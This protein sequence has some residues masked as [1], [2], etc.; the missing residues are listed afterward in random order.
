MEVLVGPSFGIDVGDRSAADHQHSV[1]SCLFLEDGIGRTGDG[2]GF[3]LGIGGRGK[4]REANE[5]SSESSSSIGAPDDSEDEEDDCASSKEVLSSFKG[6]GLG[7]MGSMEDTL[8][9]KYIFFP[10]LS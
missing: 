2:A 5:E 1:S 6:A 4:G 9:I 8:P 7:S 10:L 3:V